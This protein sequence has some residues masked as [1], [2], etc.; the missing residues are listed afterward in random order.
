[1][2]ATL[3]IYKDCASQ[4]PTKKYICYRILYGVSKKALALSQDAENKM[5][6]EQEAAMV[7]LLQAIFPEFEANELEFVDPAELGALINALQRNAN[8]EMRRVEKN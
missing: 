2:V 1:M 6:E 8:A 4:D 5:I 7:E 3:G